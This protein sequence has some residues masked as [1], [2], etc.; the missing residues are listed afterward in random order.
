MKISLQKLYGDCD[1]RAIAGGVMI[2]ADFA[3][4]LLSVIERDAAVAEEDDD[5]TQP[6]YTLT[7]PLSL[8]SSIAG[9]TPWHGV[10]RSKITHG[11]KQTCPTRNT[12]YLRWDS[13][14][15]ARFCFHS[16]RCASPTATELWKQRPSWPRL[17]PHV[18]MA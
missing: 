15:C 17:S 10:T 4:N 8:T 6:L 11:T 3:I 14:R 16:G 2:Q 18:Y 9:R 7:W 1:L 5:L 13:I 12:R